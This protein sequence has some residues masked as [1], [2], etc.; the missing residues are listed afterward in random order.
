[1]R[2]LAIDPSVN[3]IGWALYDTT[4]KDF[5]SI[6]SWNFGWFSPPDGGGLTQ[7]MSS[8]KLHFSRAVADHLVCERPMFFDSERGRIAAKEG[9]TNNL[10]M[11]I[12]TIYGCLPSI[13]LYL[14]TPQQ[15][16]G[17]VSKE[18]TLVKFR[19]IF[20]DKG[21]YNPVHDTVDAIMLLRYHVSRINIPLITMV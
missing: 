1:M 18:I 19:K 2:I 21:P 11:V 6:E 20:K 8:I 5:N 3:R 9:Y 4:A 12:G 15:W 17:S 16:K 7:K 10:A 13:Q 14:Y